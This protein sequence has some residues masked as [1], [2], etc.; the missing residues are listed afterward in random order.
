M[1][2][3]TALALL[4]ARPAI[5]QDPDTDYL[6]SV[7]SPEG[8]FTS[9]SIPPCID[10]VNIEAACAPNGTSTHDLE[11]HVQCMC[12]GS[13]FPEWIGCR[14]CLFDHGGLHEHN[15][16]SYKEV[17]LFESVAAAAT[18]PTTGGT[19]LSDIASGNTAVSV[20]YTASRSHGPGQTTGSA[21]A[22]TA[23]GSVTTDATSTTGKTTSG[24]TG[25]G[26]KTT[27]ASFTKT[28]STS[29]SGNVAAPTGMA[30]GSSSLFVMAGGTLV[31]AL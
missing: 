20:Y 16:T 2:I 18:V 27:A 8:D 9:G 6:S 7:Y 29:S 25:S 19:T 5:A 21:T 22:A 14:Q 24:A 30:A 26:S 12:K 15:L 1:T 23:T 4:A 13:Y 11:A 28:S 17:T 3:S 10:I 31:A